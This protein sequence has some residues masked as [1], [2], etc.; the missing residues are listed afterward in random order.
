MQ[1]DKTHAQFPHKFPFDRTKKLFIKSEN[2][3]EKTLARELWRKREI[4][5]SWTEFHSALRSAGGERYVESSYKH[6]RLA[7]YFVG[8]QVYTSIKYYSEVGVYIYMYMKMNR[9]G[10]S[11]CATIGKRK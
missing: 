1:D 6:A 5:P 7:R 8:I 2:A 3:P 11:L 9:A 4:A 10:R